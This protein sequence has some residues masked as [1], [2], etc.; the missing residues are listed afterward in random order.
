VK[1][2][3]RLVSRYFREPTFVDFEDN[4]TY[5]EVASEPWLYEGVSV[6]WSGQT[7]TY[8]VTGD[9]IRF[10]LLVGYETERMLE[11]TVPVIVTDNQ[12]IRP[13][14]IELIGRV[15]YSR[16]RDRADSNKHAPDRREGRSLMRA[17]V[18]RVRAASVRVEGHVVGAI[19][20]GLLVY[21]GVEQNDTDRDLVYVATK[22]AGARIFRTSEGRMNL[23]L[24]DLP[25]AR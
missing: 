22:V 11:G 21:V 10:T 17:V 20:R 24:S 5:E 16:R 6:R 7:R 1:E 9:A 3:I 14:G 18:E 25:G 12:D 15:S 8:R 23:A 13:G 19:E 2:R 4:F